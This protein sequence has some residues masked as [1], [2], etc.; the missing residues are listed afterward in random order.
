[1]AQKAKSHVCP[2]TVSGLTGQVT[3]SVRL[4][5][6]FSLEINSLLIHVLSDWTSWF[7]EFYVLFIVV[8]GDY[9]YP[10]LCHSFTVEYRMVD[11]L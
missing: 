1:M 3:D 7:I 9:L 11:Q 6:G 10:Y 2:V 5:T 4:V 8:S